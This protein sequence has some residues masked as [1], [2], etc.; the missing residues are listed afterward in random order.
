MHIY[1]TNWGHLLI[2]Q[3]E[4]ELALNRRRNGDRKRS[5]RKTNGSNTTSNT[6]RSNGHQRSNV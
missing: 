1:F 6:F 5:K 3:R 4:F 2:E